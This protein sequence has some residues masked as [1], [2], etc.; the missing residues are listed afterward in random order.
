MEND[1]GR[2]RGAY[3]RKEK[4]IQ[5]FDVESRRKEVALNTWA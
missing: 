2:T 4:C 3:G 1:L 5:G